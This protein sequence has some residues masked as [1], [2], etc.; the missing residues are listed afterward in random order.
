MAGLLTGSVWG[1]DESICLCWPAYG[2]QSSVRADSLPRG[3]CQLSVT[4]L[5]YQIVLN[6]VLPLAGS[7][8]E[9]GLLMNCA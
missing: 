7:A 8:E 6:T 1:E 2:V 9:D 4:L 5:N 3:F